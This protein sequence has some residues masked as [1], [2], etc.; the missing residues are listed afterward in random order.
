MTEYKSLTFLSL[1]LIRAQI[2]AGRTEAVRCVTLRRKKIMRRR[3]APL[4]CAPGLKRL[5][6]YRKIIFTPPLMCCK[7]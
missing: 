7:P 6:V 2:K 1:R 3:N 4:C 5:R